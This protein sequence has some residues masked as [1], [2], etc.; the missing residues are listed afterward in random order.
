[1]VP[2]DVPVIAEVGGPASEVSPDRVEQV[3]GYA[4]YVGLE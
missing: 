3:G 1:V 2:V 4:G